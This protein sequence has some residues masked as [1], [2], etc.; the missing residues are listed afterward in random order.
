VGFDGAIAPDT[1]AAAPPGTVAADSLARGSY[2]L[3]VSSLQAFRRAYM[4][5]WDAPPLR[6]ERS[7]YEAVRLLGWAAATAESGDDGDL[8]KT[9]E[10][11]H[12][13]RFGGFEIRLGA[14]DHVV[15]ERATIGLW[16]VPRPGAA[17]R[18]REE[19]PESLPWVPLARTFSGP[20]GR[21][22]LPPGEW[23][24]LFTGVEPSGPP[25]RFTQ[26]RVGVTTPEDDPVH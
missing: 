16:V 22:R 11:L 5:W 14:G 21:T 7:S 8:A 24:E 19:L 9:L 17:V 6:W 3:P 25:P 23:E 2:Y 13:R 15:A 12:G 4:A 10:G 1:A 18:E 20:G 26:M